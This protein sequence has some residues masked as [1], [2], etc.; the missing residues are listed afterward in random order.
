MHIEKLQ[1]TYGK[2]RYAPYR[3][4][5]EP[6]KELE[7]LQKMLPLYKSDLQPVSSSRVDKN[8]SVESPCL[9][10]ASVDSPEKSGNKSV[11]ED[12]KN[13][14]GYGTDDE[15]EDNI[16]K[17]RRKALLK[18]DSGNGSDDEACEKGCDEAD[19]EAS[20]GYVTQVDPS[21]DESRGHMA[22]VRMRG[23]LTNNT[24]GMYTLSL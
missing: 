2:F 6:D 18:R 3:T 11:Q 14:E 16:D 19:D 13:M 10:E 1:K 9:S 24:S 17:E 12:D 15:V 20:D 7:Q 22:K 4:V 21:L 5:F 23:G 8:A